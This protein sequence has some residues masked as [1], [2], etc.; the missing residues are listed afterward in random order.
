MQILSI[1]IFMLSSAG[2]FIFMAYIFLS[3]DSADS[4][5]LIIIPSV[6][7]AYFILFFLFRWNEQRHSGK[8]LEWIY[9]NSDSIKN[10]TARYRKRP[11]D[12]TTKL[13]QYKI[14][15]SF[16]A[17]T[18]KIDTRLMFGGGAVSNITKIFCTLFT[19]GFGWWGIPWGPV[20]TFSSILHNLNTSTYY[21]A[22]DLVRGVSEA[23]EES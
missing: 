5:D 23:P 15:I 21:L 17:F 4:S 1:L 10:G 12:K 3:N 18:A 19:T 20:Y 13:V 7:A 16:I 8:I 14:C 11:V 9:G 2:F 22:G 6:L